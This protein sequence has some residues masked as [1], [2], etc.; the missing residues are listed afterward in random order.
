[1][2]KAVINFVYLMNDY[3]PVRHRLLL[4][5]DVEF[6]DEAQ[7][8]RMRAGRTSPPDQGVFVAHV[9]DYREQVAFVVQENG[10]LQKGFREFDDV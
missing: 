5:N 10:D 7:R 8:Q 3:L 2:E 1:M 4:P 6:S 9:F